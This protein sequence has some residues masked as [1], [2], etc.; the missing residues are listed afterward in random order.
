MN[1]YVKFTDSFKIICKKYGD[2]T[3]ILIILKDIIIKQYNSSKK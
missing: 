1:I 3:K 2:E